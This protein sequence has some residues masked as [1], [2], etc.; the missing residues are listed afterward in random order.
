KYAVPCL[1]NILDVTYGCIVYQEQVMKIFQVM[2]GYSLGQADNVRRIM[3]KKKAALMPA[4]KQK[5]IYGWEDPEGKKSIPGALKLGSPIEAAEQIFGEM[6]S[7]AA[8]AFNKS[9]ATVYAY[10]AYQTAYLMC[11]Y[12]VYFLCSVLNNRITFSD[13]IKK[14]VMEVKSRGYKVLRP[15]INKSQTCFSVEDGNLRFGLAAIKNVGVAV[16]DAIIEE[17]NKNGEFKDLV[18]FIK[19]VDST[20]HN[21]RCLESLILAGAFDCFGKTRSQLMSV[22]DLAVSREANARKQKATGQFSLFD[23]FE[24]NTV[25]DKLDY[26]NIK[27]FND[28]AKLKFEKEVVGIYISGH[29]LDEYAD[30]FKEFNLKSSMLKVEEEGDEENEEDDTPKYSADIQPDMKVTCGG[31]LENVRKQITKKGNREMG[32]AELEDLWGTI[33]LT[34]FPDA[35]RRFKELVVDDNLVTIKGR[36]SLRDGENASVVVE[37]VTAWKKKAVENVVEEKKQRLCLKFNTMDIELYNKVISIIGTYPG[38]NEVYVRCTETGKAFKM[39]K[40]TNISNHL[41]NEL[42]GALGEDNVIVQ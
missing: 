33:E 11:Y 19:R 27:E 18:D 35:Y 24:E 25:E 14:Y 8:Y 26:P 6:E 7:F 20:A 41:E 1:E 37:D 21:K 4:E 36:L 5:F 13:E 32:F 42:V 30:K 15:D 3:S 28:D 17:R 9:H 34:F 40:T 29:P 10:L 2:G 38:E 16:I 23:S 31:I 39:N 12:D 22:Y